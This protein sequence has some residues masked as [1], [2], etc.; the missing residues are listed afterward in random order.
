MTKYYVDIINAAAKADPKGFIE[1]CSENYISSVEDAATIMLDKGK[2]VIMLA[3]PSSSGKT[4][5]AKILENTMEKSGCE[6][7]TVSLDDFYLP[8]REDYPRN[9]DGSYNF[10]SIEALDI[11]MIKKCFTE[12]IE[13]GESNLPIYDF[14]I[15]TRSDQVNNIRLGKDGVM[16]VEGIH[17]LN[18]I[19]TDCL[20]NDAMARLYVSVSTRI[21]EENGEIML[22]KR[23]LRLL[24][25]LVR[26]NR[27]RDTNAEGTLATWKS[28][29]AGE[30]NYIFPFRNHADIKLDSFHPCEIGLL[31]CEAMELL[32]GVHGTPYDLMAE[33]LLEKIR[34]FR[35]IDRSYLKCESLL[36]EFLG[37]N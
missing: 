26:D 12:L 34:R 6:V 33:N 36:Y 13:D 16:I 35:V 29:M 25:R 2:K 21:F 23:N 28:V 27:F 14:G 22:R 3:G 4:T 37:K 19:I 10:E 8:N 20:P 17:G 1:Q 5:T 18:P 11:P 30:D 24:R 7:Y 15:Q 32:S 31:A 9:K